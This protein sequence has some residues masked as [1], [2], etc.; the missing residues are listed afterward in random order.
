MHARIGKGALV[1]GCLALLSSCTTPTYDEMKTGIQN[2]DVLVAR[3]GAARDG[4]VAAGE[5]FRVVMDTFYKMLDPEGGEL[6][7]RYK[8]LVREYA[9]AEKKAGEVNLQ[10][11]AV[12]QAAETL[13][14]E[15]EADLDEYTTESLRSS[16][17][18]KLQAARAQYASLVETMKNTEAKMQPILATL[19]DHVLFL[20]HSLNDEGIASLQGSVAS[21][22]ADLDSLLDGIRK[23]VEEANG[24]IN[25]LV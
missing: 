25:E 9:L 3:V 7:W 13:F 21:L 14:A 20:K 6:V 17:E 8:N 15:W 10:I 2:R 5:Q 22:Q 16:S 1:V 12:E 24:F 19:H 18:Q 23:T 4:F 11:A